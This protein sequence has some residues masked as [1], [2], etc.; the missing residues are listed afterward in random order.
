M[1]S[2][3]RAGDESIS[4]Y[5]ATSSDQELEVTQRQSRPFSWTHRAGQRRALLPASQ[6]CFLLLSAALV[7]FNVQYSST[8]TVHMYYR[9]TVPAQPYQLV[10]VVA[11]FVQA[12][13]TQV[14]HVLA[15][16]AW[17]DVIELPQHSVL[18]DVNH[19]LQAR[20]RSTGSTHRQH[21][22][23]NCNWEGPLCAS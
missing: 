18:C 1:C 14:S 17:A 15:V 19:N 8:G 10:C 12:V 22:Q 13:T 7:Y 4:A 3:G 23:N 9:C 11:V 6:T 20:S 21:T 16:D 2:Q 5:E